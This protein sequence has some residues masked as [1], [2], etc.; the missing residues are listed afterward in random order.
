MGEV[1][2]CRFQVSETVSAKRR[3]LNRFFCFVIVEM[4]PADSRSGQEMRSGDKN[5]SKMIFYAILGMGKMPKIE[6]TTR[7]IA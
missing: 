3:P 1:P 7:N 6:S 4:G 2:L 5:S